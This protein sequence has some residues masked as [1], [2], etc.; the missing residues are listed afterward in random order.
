MST[1]YIVVSVCIWRSYLFM[2]SCRTVQTFSKL[3]CSHPFLLGGWAQG[4]GWRLERI[5]FSLQKQ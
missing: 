2:P 5:R 4:A 1:N 3:E